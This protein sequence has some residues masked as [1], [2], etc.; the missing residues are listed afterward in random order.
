MTLAHARLVG[1]H[2]VAIAVEKKED[3]PQENIDD[4][5]SY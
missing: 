5:R 2:G 1:V 4:T 3:V